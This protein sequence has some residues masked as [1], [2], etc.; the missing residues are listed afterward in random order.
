MLDD[1]PLGELGDRDHAIGQVGRCR[2]MPVT[3]VQGA[4]RE[5]F[6]KE[7]VLDVGKHHHGRQWNRAR[8]KRAERAEEKIEPVEMAPDLAL[9]FEQH[10]ALA[11]EPAVELVELRGIVR[12]PEEHIVVAAV[13]AQQLVEQHQEILLDAADRRSQV[14]PTT[15]TCIIILGA[16][17]QLPKEVSVFFHQL[18]ELVI[19]SVVVARFLLPMDAAAGE[20]RRNVADRGAGQ[21]HAQPQIIVHPVVQMALHVG[22]R[23]LPDPSREEY[24]QH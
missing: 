22:L 7:D 23:R 2:E 19:P 20:H 4:R 8:K 3:R 1:R 15:L 14:A 10:R 13:V 17:F 16:R 21:R 6:G 9:A 24:F 12:E 18:P 11:P 5:E